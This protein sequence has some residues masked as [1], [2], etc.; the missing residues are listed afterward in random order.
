MA[1]EIVFSAKNK[2]ELQHV[3]LPPL[4]QHEVRGRT[5]V[6]LISPGTEIA[7]LSGESFPIRPGYAAIFVAEETGPLVSGIDAGEHLFCMGPHRSMQQ[8]NYRHALKVPQKLTPEVAVL[9]RLA[10]VSM[11]TLMST[12]ARPGD[13]VI[14]AGAGPV[15]LLASQLFHLSGYEVCVVDP[16]PVRCSQVMAAGV[17]RVYSDMP[18]AELDIAGRA[19]LVADCSGHEEAVLQGCRIVRPHGEVVLVGVPWRRRTELHAHDVLHAVFNNFVH[20][21]SGWEWELP[22]L[23]R[24]FKWEQLLEGYNNQPQSVFSGFEKIMRWLAEGR[25]WTEGLI[26]NVP[27]ADASRAYQNL[28]A[29]EFDEPFCV[30]SWSD[31]RANH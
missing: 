2:A 6:T 28:V 18:F 31:A 7:W 25:I 14:I 13:L 8:V 30:L 1:I 23:S 17:T 9:A 20:L 5:V 15:G 22:V 29:R 26:R 11:T 16:D 21:R 19:A 12:K 27:S 24:N 3:E 10:G 4:G